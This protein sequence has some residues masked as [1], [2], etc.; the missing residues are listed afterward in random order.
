MAHLPPGR[1]PNRL[2]SARGCRVYRGLVDHTAAL[3]RRPGREPE[4]SMVTAVASGTSGHDAPR[5][6]NGSAA[7]NLRQRRKHAAALLAHQGNRGCRA[8]RA[9]GALNPLSSM[10]MAGRIE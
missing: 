9:L 8:G 10:A 7:P 1:V 5:H 3:G 6:T 4:L 2:D